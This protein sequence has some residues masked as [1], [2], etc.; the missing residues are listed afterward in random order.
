MTTPGVLPRMSGTAYAA[1]EVELGAASLSP[2]PRTRAAVSEAAVFRAVLAKNWALKWRG[3]VCCCSGA[4]SACERLVACANACAAPCNAALEI[5]VPLV[6][7][8]LLCL[9]R[10]LIADTQFPAR[11][12]A[13]ANMTALS[14]SAVRLHHLRLLA[15]WY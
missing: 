7:L 1:M 11:F 10:Y 13:P 14:W 2:A 8:G 9:P 5:L 12:F 3:L 15:V 6:F 4:R